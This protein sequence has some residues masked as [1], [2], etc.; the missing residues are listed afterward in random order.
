MAVKDK[1]VASIGMAMYEEMRA[2][3]EANE[4][5]AWSSSM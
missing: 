2:E 4:W 1:D 5:G 3:M